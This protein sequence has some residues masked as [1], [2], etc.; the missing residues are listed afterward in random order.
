MRE[1]RTVRYSSAQGWKSLSQE[2]MAEA[3][4]SNIMKYIS[5]TLLPPSLHQSQTYYTV[6]NTPT[7][8]VIRSVLDSISSCGEEPF[9]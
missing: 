6:L 5:S 8:A 1:R 7:F 3:L 2:M 9:S 4:S